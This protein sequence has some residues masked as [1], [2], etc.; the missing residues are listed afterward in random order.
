MHAPVNDALTID[1]PL[2]RQ[3]LANGLRVV[4]H[5]DHRLPLVAVNLWYHVGSKNERPGRTG[6]AHL[7]EHLL[8]EG[9]AHVGPQEHFR[10][11]QEAGG[12]TNGSTWYDRTNYHET[13][14]SHQLDLGLWLES[15]RLGFAFDALDQH[16]LDTQ[17]EVVINERRQRVDNQPYGLA[18][19]RLHELLYAEDHP[20]RWPVIGYVDD[21]HAARLDD[22]RRFFQTFYTPRNAVLTVAGDIEPDNALDRIDRWFGELPRGGDIPPVVVPPN[23]LEGVRRDVLHDRVQLPRLYYGF[24]GPAFGTDDW[25]ALDLWSEAMAEGKASV[26]YEDLVYRRRLAQEVACYIYPTEESA[27]VL[28]MATARPEVPI[29]TLEQAIDEHLNRAA[30]EPL[31]EAQL[32]SAKRRLLTGHFNQLQNVEQRA[33]L[34]SRFTTFF[35]RP[36]DLASEALRYQPVE[37]EDVRRAVAATCRLDRRAIVTVL[38]EPA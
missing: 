14:P 10:Y 30:R 12:V 22:V 33:D 34:L 27:T 6:L 28:V 4:L 37:A 29:E 11:V 17:R 20:Y 7:F 3:T 24:H 32:A 5:P 16:S 36:E 8:F 21:L 23:P 31:S 13:L 25:Y 26:L 1:L 35:D 15:D 9:S 2:V 38:P 18:N 19:E